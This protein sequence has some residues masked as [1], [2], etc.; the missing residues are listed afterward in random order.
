MFLPVGI[1]IIAL[2][3]SFQ[4][5]GLYFLSYALAAIAGGIVMTQ[6]KRFSAPD[7]KASSGMIATVT[8]TGIALI[9]L[10]ASYY[11]SRNAGTFSLFS[12]A[13]KIW[14]LGLGFGFM[15]GLLIGKK[16]PAQPAQTT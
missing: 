3:N 9:A 5:A 13:F 1:F 6:A 7:A 16:D 8:M 14:H 12:G 15:A 4:A 11:V 10:V 2:E